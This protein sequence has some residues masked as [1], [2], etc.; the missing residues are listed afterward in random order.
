M[1]QALALMA[2]TLALLAAGQAMA[3]SQAVALIVFGAIGVMA[4]MIAATFFWLWFE[5]TTP[6]A[7]G[8]AY[9]W[10]GAGLFAA[11]AW[12]DALSGQAMWVSGPVGGLLAQ[13]LCL[14]GALLH[15]AVI[16]RSFG[17]HGIGFLAPV[18]VAFGLS[19]FAYLVA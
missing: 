2:L 10:A 18:A 16:H 5:R 6:L 17:R 13:S 12:G 7:L 1:K 15:F 4:L 14:A 3:G 9:A 11:M 19:G 8:M